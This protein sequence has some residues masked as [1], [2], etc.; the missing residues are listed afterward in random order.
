MGLLP[1]FLIA[2][3]ALALQGQP[4]PP[5][6]IAVAAPAQDAG[7]LGGRAVLLPSATGQVGRVI[8]STPTSTQDLTRAYS[9]VN[10]GANGALTTQQDSA[11]SI[12][13]RYGDLLAA[14]PRPAT[15]HVLYFKAGN[16]ELTPESV[17]KLDA[18]LQDAKARSA[19]EF[20]VIGHTD[21]T[22]VATDNQALSLQRAQSVVDRLTA[23]GV[24][25]QSYEAVGR[26]SLDLLVPTGPNVDEPRNRRVE[27][28]VR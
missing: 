12:A 17:A 8:V 21:T 9:A 10:V 13:V 7:A 24:K 14:R 15:S 20:R 18:V 6:A 4:T 27:I 11:E 16:A 26:G 1:I 22:G 25:A 19:P 28:S 3:G 5:T 23:S 2:A